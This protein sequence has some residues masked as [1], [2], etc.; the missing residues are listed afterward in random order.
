[1]FEAENENADDFVHYIQRKKGKSCCSWKKCC[2]STCLLW[3]LSSISVATTLG[4]LI[5]KKYIIV[6]FQNPHYTIEE[7]N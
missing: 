5:W 7:Y 2:I 4:I 1:M 6:D 3:T